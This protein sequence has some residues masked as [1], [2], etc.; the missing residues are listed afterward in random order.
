MFAPATKGLIP[1][2]PKMDVAVPFTT[3]EGPIP[4]DTVT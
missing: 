4:G 3:T 2:V 1:A